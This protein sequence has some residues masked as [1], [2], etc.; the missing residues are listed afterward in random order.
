MMNK[1][2][3]VT[4]KIFLAIAI[5]VGLMANIL[6]IDDHTKIEMLDVSLILFTA[7]II[8]M[9]WIFVRKGR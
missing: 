7:A 3:S 5:I 9:A 2:F 6:S 8:R 1:Y 4:T